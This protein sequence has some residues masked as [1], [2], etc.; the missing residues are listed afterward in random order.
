VT[1]ARWIG[2]CM[3]P[4]LR[5]SEFRVNAQKVQ[6]AALFSTL[7][8]AAAIGAQLALVSRRPCNQIKLI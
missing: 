4:L 7:G 6:I 1:V 8:T 5:V 3:R 2:E